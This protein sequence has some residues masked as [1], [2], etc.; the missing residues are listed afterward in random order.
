MGTIMGLPAT[1]APSPSP[2][3]AEV[4]GGRLDFPPSLLRVTLALEGG[5][6]G[7]TIKRGVV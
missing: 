1:V 7:K 2:F 3:L 5:E 4:D 6:V